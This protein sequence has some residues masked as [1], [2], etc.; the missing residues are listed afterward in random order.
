VLRALELHDLP[1][2]RTRQVASVAERLGIASAEIQA[3][4]GVLELTATKLGAAL[5]RRPRWCRR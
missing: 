4:L 3:A 5:A 1:S 2:G